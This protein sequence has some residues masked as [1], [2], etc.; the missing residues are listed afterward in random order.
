MKITHVHTQV[1]KLPADEPLANGPE[2]A[3]VT[4]DFVVLGIGTDQGIERIGR[5][6]SFEAPLLSTLKTAVDAL[7]ALAVGADALRIEA[8]ME[9]L[10]NAAHSCGPGGILTLALSAIDTALWDIKGKACQQPLS[11]L[12]GGYRQRVPTYA[13]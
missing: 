8:T 7:G 12:L 9:K 5:T 11:L 2:L 6:G 1:V 3:G 10:R 4:R 13:S